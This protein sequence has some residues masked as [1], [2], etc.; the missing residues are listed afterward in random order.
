MNVDE[1]VAAVRAAVPYLR[2]ALRPEP[3]ERWLSCAVLSDDPEQ[4]AAVVATTKAGRGL[5]RD[6][7]A[8]SLFAQ[9]YAFR[10]AS[11]AV[12]TW[13][14]AGV[15]P[16]LDPVAMSIS[17]GRDRPNEVALHEPRRTE[18]SLPD[19]VLAHLGPFVATAHR[20]S[21]IGERLLWGNVAASC[22]AAFGAFNEALG[23]AAT[24]T[25]FEGFLPS[26]DLSQYGHIVEREA[27]PDNG[28]WAWQ[29]TNC[30]LWYQAEGAAGRRCE[31]CSLN[32]EE[33]R[34]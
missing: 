23:T 7:V 5:E 13:L 2:V 15:V 31:D 10:I 21:R 14:L 29:R 25:A 22:A 30:C 33:R 11:L 16:D 19:E 20:A 6:D 3:D 8:L 9:A 28:G 18:R 26:S 34:A 4:M 27:E 17:L 1:A 32:L 24:R 12:G